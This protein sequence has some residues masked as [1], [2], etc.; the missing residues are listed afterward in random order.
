[1]KKLVQRIAVVKTAI[2]VAFLAFPV[3]VLAVPA[4]P[5]INLET[6]LTGKL[7]VFTVAAFISFIIKLL[8]LVAFIVAFIFLVIGGIRWITAGGDPKGVEAARNTVTAALI[9]LVIVLSAFA[10]IKLIEFFFNITII[11]GPIEIPQIAP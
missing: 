8:L 9:G 7:P 10:L 5:N 2:G 4:Q 3:S 6:A 1:M 11:S